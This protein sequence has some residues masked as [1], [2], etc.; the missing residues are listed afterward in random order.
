[1]AA[2]T[3]KS[4]FRYVYFTDTVYL[5]CDNN[6]YSFMIWVCNFSM[7][8]DD[9]RRVHSYAQANTYT[10]TKH[11]LKLLYF[12]RFGDNSASR[13]DGVLCAPRQILNLKI[14]WLMMMMM[15][16]GELWNGLRRFIF[17]F[18]EHSALTEVILAD[19]SFHLKLNTRLR[20]PSPICFKLRGSICLEKIRN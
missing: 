8:P 19:Q 11:N 14:K 18:G 4:L 1:M 7:M 3:L 2:S 16:R 9:A 17:S 6:N 15:S 20:V 10:Y 5:P 13:D 12:F